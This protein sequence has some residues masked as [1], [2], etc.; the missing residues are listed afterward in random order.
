MNHLKDETSPYLL[1]HAGNPVNWFPWTQEALDKA[2]NENKL[3][4]ISIGYSACHWCHVMEHECFED[5]EVAEVMNRN[6]ISIK[7]DREERPDI[8]HVYM[9]ASYIITGR[10]GWPL[11]VIALPDGMPVYA[12]TYF[13]KSDWLTVLNHFALLYDRK[14]EELR[15]IAKTIHKE[16]TRSS[17]PSGGFQTERTEQWNPDLIFEKWLP[18]LD[19]TNGG[20]KGAPKFP[21]PNNLEF[22][23]EYAH[24]S[25]NNEARRAVELS[26]EK[27]SLGG[28]FDHLGGGF[29][30]YSTDDHWHIPHFEKMLYDNAQLVSL[31]SHAYQYFRNPLYKEIVYSTMKFIELELTS[32]EGSFYSSIDADSEGKEGKYYAWSTIEIKDLLGENADLFME[33]YNISIEGNW[34]DGLN[35]LYRKKDETEIASRYSISADEL[36][37][38][39]NSA[40]VILFNVREHRMHPEK[41][42]KILAS[43]NAL[44]ISG[45]ISAS[46]AFKEPVYLTKAIHAAEVFSEKYVQKDGKLLRVLDNDLKVINGFLDDYSFMIKA[47][48]ELYQATFNE[49]W[50]EKTELLINYALTHFLDSQ[51]GLFYY[52]SDTEVALINRTMEMSD[53]VIASSNSQMGINLFILGHLLSH[54]K[55]IDHAQRMITY[56]RREMESNPNYYANWA[57]LLT[58]LMRPPYEISILGPNW[59]NLHAELR[60]LYLPQIILSGGDT[61]ANLEILKGKLVPGKSLIYVCRDKV[62]QLPVDNVENVL[63]LM[64]SLSLF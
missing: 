41:D 48:V 12:G 8:D 5:R 27:M 17:K 13:P 58:Y 42:T 24:L 3:L 4:I 64:T 52:T 33:F 59:R 11:N 22:I 53:N 19:L 10:G 7:V 38:R 50:L 20:T 16:V 32:L 15:N 62:C 34:E 36:K 37:D 35:V 26:L 39:I 28:I 47:F 55:W 40:K 2:R 23:M 44:M 45:Y 49:Q 21:T 6:Y 56:V 51:T 25:G 54:D 30:R 60:S 18:I 63:G 46:L 61:E 31:Y 14:N 29:C 43:W 1:Q 9:S 57:I